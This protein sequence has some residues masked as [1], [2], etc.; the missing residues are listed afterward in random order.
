MRSETR[1]SRRRKAGRRPLPLASFMLSAKER[2][3]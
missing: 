1:F 3:L 2:K